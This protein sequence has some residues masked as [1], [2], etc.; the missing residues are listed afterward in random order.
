[1]P[2]RGE[3]IL[4]I[5]P[6]QRERQAIVETL[7]PRGFSVVAPER[8]DGATERSSRNEYGLVILDLGTLGNDWA[9][10]LARL[11]Q[12]SPQTEVMVTASHGSIEAAVEAMREGAYDYLLKPL[13]LARLSVLV[14]RA[15][16]KRRLAEAPT[17]VTAKRVRFSPK[18]LKADRKR[19]GLSAQDYGLLVGVTA[20]TIYNWESGT[21]KPGAKAS[22]GWAA[23][24]GIGKREALGRLELIEG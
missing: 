14:E 16:E 11:K 17:H 19:L 24:R 5:E 2:T 1:M 13:D 21:T 8:I 10:R 22:A 18:W 23:V 3:R 4:V 7:S 15:L 20:Q 12:Q 6:E 9:D